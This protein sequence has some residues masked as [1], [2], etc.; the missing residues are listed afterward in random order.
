[1]VAPTPGERAV[2]GLHLTNNLLVWEAG[3]IQRLMDITN[4]VDKAMVQMEQNLWWSPESDAEKKKR[5]EVEGTI[6]FDQVLDVD[7]MLN[8]DF[9]PANSAAELFGMFAP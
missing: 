2:E 9:R 1:V 5:G 4:N 8:T 7:P 6:L 3:G